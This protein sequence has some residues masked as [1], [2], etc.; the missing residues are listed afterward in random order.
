MAPVTDSLLSLY[1][2]D[3][4]GEDAERSLWKK[5]LKNWIWHD[6]GTTGL[7]LLN[8]ERQIAPDEQVGTSHGSIGHE[9]VVSRLEKCC[10]N[11]SPLTKPEGIDYS[12]TPSC[13]K[14][15]SS[16]QEVSSS[17]TPNNADICKP[18]SPTAYS[19]SSAPEVPALAQRQ[20]RYPRWLLSTN[21]GSSCKSFSLIANVI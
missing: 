14:S 1:Q 13:D 5:S 18:Q 19:W 8:T 2:W 17:V 9:Y 11:E 12:F 10:M 6:Q 21:I 3:E 20:V 7:K 4:L 16:S 15:F